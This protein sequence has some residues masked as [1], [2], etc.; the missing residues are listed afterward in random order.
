MI[1]EM[2]WL[3]GAS[4]GALEQT[5][6]VIINGKCTQV[7][8]DI[9]ENTTNNITYTVAVTTVDGGI[10]YSQA[11]IPDNG[12]TIYRAYSMGGTD[13]DFEAFLM[14]EVVTVTVTASGDPGTT[15]ATVNVG[16]Y[17]E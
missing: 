2:A 7:E 11:T 15:G 17:I 13:S 3:N 16:L 14:A 12:A 8:V 1:T 4:G 10:L 9:A 5:E 6:D